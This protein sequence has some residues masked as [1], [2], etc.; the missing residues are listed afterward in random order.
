MTDT[1]QPLW[2]SKSLAEMTREEWESLCDGCGWC[3]VHK[4]ADQNDR[5]HY[6]RIACRLMDLE[7][8]RCTS[9]EERREL[10]PDCTILTPENIDSLH[11]M[12]S[13]CAYRLLAQG[14]DLPEWHPLVTGD[15]DSP[16]KAGWSRRWMRGSWRSSRRRGGEREF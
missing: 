10:M 16:H 1:T 13:T 15:P 11:W 3:C 4:F 8:C 5:V 14:K 12:P 7:T 9:Y 6:T 2:K